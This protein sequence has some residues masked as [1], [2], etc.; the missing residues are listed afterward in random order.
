MCRLVNCMA[1]DKLPTFVGSKNHPYVERNNFF[2][3]TF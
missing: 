3:T 2:G 1:I